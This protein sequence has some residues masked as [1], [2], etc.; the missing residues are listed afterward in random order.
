MPTLLLVMPVPE[1]VAA[2]LVRRIEASDQAPDTI[3][4]DLIRSLIEDPNDSRWGGGALGDA[5][6]LI[7]NREAA[8]KLDA[9]IRETRP[10]VAHLHNIY[11]HLSPSILPVLRRHGIPV[12]MTLHDL[13]LL[14][15][16]IHMLRQD[17][18]CERCKGGRFYNAIRY[19]CK[20]GSAAASVIAAPSINPRVIILLPSPPCVYV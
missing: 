19:R 3:I 4:A 8:R 15:P 7:W 9:L 12:V 6:N 10:D 5:V 1:P 13:R 14:C 11:H 17:E 18:V 20:R 16:A 2:E